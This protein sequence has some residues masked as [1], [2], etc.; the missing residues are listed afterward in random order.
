[1]PRR[2]VLIL[3]MTKMRSGICTA[4]FTTEADPVSGLKWVR[5][6]KEHSTLLLGDMTDADGRVVE[7]FDVVSLDL[8]AARPDA[9]HVEDWITDFV[10]ERPR[11]L[12]RLEGARRSQFLAKY[13]DQAPDDV[14]VRGTRSLCLVEPDELWA[15]FELDAYSGKYQARLGFVVDGIRHPRASAP[16][17]VPVT[18]LK[19]RALGRAW[20]G[21]AGGRLDLDAAE[22]KAQ[23]GAARIYL[24]LGLSRTYNGQ[25]WL[26]VVGVHADPDYTIAIDYD[27]L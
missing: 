12:R 1:M 15:R 10:Y 2:D 9:P 27:N 17:G 5:P 19:W 26:L 13:L 22:L 18:D 23:L 20:L 8:Q 24:A 21:N 11:L 25:I 14:L 16:Q 6:V 4:G 3:A 7:C